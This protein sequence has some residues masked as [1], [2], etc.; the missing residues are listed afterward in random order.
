MSCQLAA[1]VLSAGGC[2]VSRRCLFSLL[3]DVMSLSGA[4]S[5]C[6]WMSCQLA[7]SALLLVDAMSVTSVCSLCWWLS[8]QLAV[9]VPVVVVAAAAA[10]DLAGVGSCFCVTFGCCSCSCYYCCCCL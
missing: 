10:A 3:V 8:C 7:V 9:S 5:L 1:P 6:W 4:C 2:H